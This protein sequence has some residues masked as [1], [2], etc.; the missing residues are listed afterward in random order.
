M[1]TNELNRDV[2]RL[3]K[4]VEKLQGKDNTSFFAAIDSE[5]KPEF[6]RLYRADIKCEYLNLKSFKIMTVL[7]RRFRF[8]AFHQFFINIEL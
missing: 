4:S 2:N 8:V 6:M 5:I 7:N 1:T 3:L